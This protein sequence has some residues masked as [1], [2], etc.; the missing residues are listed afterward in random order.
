[1]REERWGRGAV[2]EAPPFF[3][4]DLTRRMEGRADAEAEES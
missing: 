4:A 1:M 3:Y 2:D